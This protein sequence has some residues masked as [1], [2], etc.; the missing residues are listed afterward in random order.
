MA[1]FL[2]II[3]GLVVV[4]GVVAFGWIVIVVV[5]L[6]WGGRHAYYAIKGEEYKPLFRDKTKKP[7]E[8][9]D[10]DAGANAESISAVLKRFTRAK[11]VGS[12]AK[13]GLEA[14]EKEKVHNANF[15][16]VLDKK[17]E[18]N[19]LSWSKFV[20]AADMTHK[21]ILQNCA[22]LANR[23]QVFDRAS[24]QKSELGHRS[25]TYR[26]KEAIIDPEEAEKQRV[27]QEG[28][29]EMD[30]LIASNEKLL[31]ELDKLSIELGKLTDADA[32]A[33]TEGIV[34]EIR[35]LAEETKY[36]K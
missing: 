35:T 28:L 26:E 10:V 36:Y 21:A 17:F 34:E 32:V 1:D 33:E 13:A 4:A 19:S 31:V 29:E 23:I 7:Y 15:Q 2:D 12:R 14:L 16:A 5:L 27:L 3:L 9:Q 22:A 8:H 30:K 11:V 18:P 25:S 20:T 6:I 24:Y